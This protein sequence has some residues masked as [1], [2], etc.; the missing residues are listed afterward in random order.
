MHVDGEVLPEGGLHERDETLGETAEDDAGIGVAVDRS[1]LDEEVGQLDP[2]ALHGHGEELLLGTAAAEDCSGGH[3]KSL[4]DL[5]EGSRLEA[6]LHE[7]GA[8][9]FGH[10]LRRDPWG[11]SHR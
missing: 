9:G 8:S 3:L 4:R 11:A 10:L 5:G 1:Q 2:G 7:D 6:S